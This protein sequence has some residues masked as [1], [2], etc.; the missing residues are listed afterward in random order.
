MNVGVSWIFFFWREKWV[1]H[2]EYSLRTF[3]SIHPS[4]TLQMAVF[5]VLD[6]ALSP[7]ISLLLAKLDILLPFE[8]ILWWIPF[9]TDHIA[10]ILYPR[11]LLLLPFPSRPGWIVTGSLEPSNI[12]LLLNVLRHFVIALTS[13]HTLWSFVYN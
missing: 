9:L 13:C 12:L 4:Q 2:I 1:N 5:R 3:R 7:I 11:I 10:P 8:Q 6:I